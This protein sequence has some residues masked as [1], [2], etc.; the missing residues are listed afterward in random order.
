MGARRFDADNGGLIQSPLLNNPGDANLH[1][2]DWFGLSE[3]NLP[4]TVSGGRAPALPE[5]QVAPNA[6][7][8]SGGL[9]QR[10]VERLRRCSQAMSEA[11]LAQA[12]RAGELEA[13]GL[14]EKGEAPRFGRG[15]NGG[16]YY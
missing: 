14:D 11:R 4:Q 6:P 3:S 15:G 16:R 7:V 1:F 5:A 10:L 8:A 13:A 9:W 2:V 12:R